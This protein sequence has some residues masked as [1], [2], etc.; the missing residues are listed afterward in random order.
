MEYYQVQY[1][2]LG[3]DWQPYGEALKTRLEASQQFLDLLI[4]FKNTNYAE[5]FRVVSV[6]KRWDDVWSVKEVLE[7]RDISG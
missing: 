5:A 7:Y 6:W 2:T 4:Q 1:L 3:K